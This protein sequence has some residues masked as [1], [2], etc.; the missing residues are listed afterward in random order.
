MHYIKARNA[1]KEFA[2][3]SNVNFIVDSLESQQKLCDSLMADG[4]K[5]IAKENKDGL[6]V[7]VVK[8]A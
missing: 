4:H 8:A 7:S 6:I 3:G 2:D 1:L 5:A